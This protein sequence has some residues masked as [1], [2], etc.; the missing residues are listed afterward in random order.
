MKKL[1]TVLMA[2]A[3][4]SSVVL[5]AENDYQGQIDELKLQIQ[6]LE[7]KTLED[8][9]RNAN[10]N[11]SSALTAGHET[12]KGFYIKTDD[13]MFRLN[14]NTRMHMRHTYINLD[15]NSNGNDQEGV[16]VGNVADVDN[17]SNGFEIERAYLIL[18]GN[19]GENINFLM[20]VDM[21][22]DGGRQA[23]LLDFWAQYTI[24]PE[25]YVKAGRIKSA[26]TRQSPTSSGK[27][28]FADR[29]Y[30]NML[31]GIGYGT[32]LEIGGEIA[33]G[34]TKPNWKLGIF[35]SFHDTGNAPFSDTDNN[36]A[37]AFS[38][39]VPLPGATAKDFA[40]ESDIENHATPV[41]QIGASAA[42]TSTN[43]NNNW[44]DAE[45]AYTIIGR[46][47]NDG[48][49][50]TFDGSSQVLLANINAAMKYQGLSLMAEGY[51]QNARLDS[52]TNWDTKF[53]V[54][55]SVGAVENGKIDN[56]G[57]LLQA[58]YFVVPQKFELISKISGICVDNTNDSTEYAAG[59]NWYING[60]AL[61]LT[62]D[63][64][65]IDDL[66][67]NGTRENYLGIQNESM[68]MVR[69][70]LQFTF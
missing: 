6:K 8:G 5:A 13:D 55:R 28:M 21:D 40:N 39:T 22:D 24:S 36:P 23:D 10:Q 65:Y 70:Q 62:M 47:M 25:L 64:T 44:G 1:L 18:N 20:I 27:Q 69:T 61:K 14:I 46:N 17:S 56:Y 43:E 45:D 60:Q 50:D 51:Y 38:F 52:N 9:L 54:T 2:V 63:V 68:L 19:A 57:Y 32:G 3:L 42:Y 48:K 67:S 49:S 35:N 53:G 4:C 11:Q 7:A 58:G 37:A 31:F 34:D 12:G 59:W 29:S 16:N 33:M 15:D 66:V 30:A 26:F 41:Y